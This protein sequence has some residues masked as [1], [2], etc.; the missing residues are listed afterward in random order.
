MSRGLH[1]RRGYLPLRIFSEYVRDSTGQYE[2]LTVWD[3]TTAFSNRPSKY[4]GER[5]PVVGYGTE[6][7][8][9]LSLENAVKLYMR[10]RV[11]RLK[12]SG[13]TA[14]GGTGGVASG[15]F[16]TADLWVD[17]DSSDPD[18]PY[19]SSAIIHDHRDLVVGPMP[20]FLI[21]IFDE[22]PP[23]SQQD[24]ESIDDETGD[25][26]FGTATCNMLE[27]FGETVYTGPNL[28]LAKVGDLYYPQMTFGW[29]V[30]VAA[31]NAPSEEDD[32]G[33]AEQSVYSLEMVEPSIVGAE[34]ASVPCTFFGEDL[35]LTVRCQAKSFAEGVGASAT[36]SPSDL[37][38]DLGAGP[39]GWLEYGGVYDA[40]TGA[41]IG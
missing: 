17:C 2:A 41:K 15:G 22:F 29:Q 32:G 8:F 30:Q 6:F 13:C 34:V 25:G 14:F 40:D 31:S 35:G 38:L 4:S 20:R 12:L 24:F 3:G 19:N 16:V 5:F 37:T 26:V 28:A 23:E 10:M 27:L 36:G 1:F 21:D 18:Q 7:P 33:F 39:G 11:A 9:G